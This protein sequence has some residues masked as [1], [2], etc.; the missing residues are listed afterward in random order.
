MSNCNVDIIFYDIRLSKPS[1]SVYP[2]NRAAA[3]KGCILKNTLTELL[4]HL[5]GHLTKSK[6]ISCLISELFSVNKG[7]GVENKVVVQV[8]FGVQMS[9]DYY[10]ISVA[11][12]ALCCFN[13]DSVALLG[14]YLTLGKALIAVIC[15]YLILFTELLFGFGHHFIGSF[16]LAVDTGNEQFIIRFILVTCVLNYIFKGSFIRILCIVQDL[17]QRARYLPK[18]SCC[19]YLFLL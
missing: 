8:C 19:H 18:R 2:I 1:V 5:I 17:F 6:Y 13:T 11:P 3:V 16:N 4:A 14:S 15:D 7:H 10:L 12:Q 9:G